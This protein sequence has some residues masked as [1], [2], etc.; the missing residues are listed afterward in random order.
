MNFILFILEKKIE[1][2]KKL[3]EDFQDKIQIENEVL[4]VMKKAYEEINNLLPLE[5]LMREKLN[6]MAKNL[7]IDDCEIVKFNVNG[8]PYATLKST[9]TRKFKKE[10]SEEFYGTN[11]L[12]ELFN[13]SLENKKDIPF[14]DRNAVYFNCVLDYLRSP[15]DFIESFGN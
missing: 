1:K 4:N 8:P 9:I 11:L 15:E 13:E 7:E 2:F 5:G 12:E 10:E 3:I 6:L 14:M